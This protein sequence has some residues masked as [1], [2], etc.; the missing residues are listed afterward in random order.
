MIKPLISPVFD[1]NL[2]AAFTK[3]D[4]EI[5]HRFSLN[6]TYNETKQLLLIHESNSGDKSS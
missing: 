4:L 2:F 3:R 1:E 5:K 6:N